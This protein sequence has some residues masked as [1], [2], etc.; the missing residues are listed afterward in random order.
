MNTESFSNLTDVAEV[1]LGRHGDEVEVV[2]VLQCVHHGRGGVKC[3]RV[4]DGAP[5]RSTCWLTA[6][7]ELGHLPVLDLAGDNFV[8]SVALLEPFDQGEDFVGR[9]HGET[10]GASVLTV[11]VVVHRGVVGA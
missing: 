2:G 7:L 3:T 9:T 5:V 6:V 4:V 11:G 8:E 1:H 10:G